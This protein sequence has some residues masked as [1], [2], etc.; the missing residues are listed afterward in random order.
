[1]GSTGPGAWSSCAAGGGQSRG[2][3]AGKAW[4]GVGQG[5]RGGLEGAGL[6]GRG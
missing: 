4:T 1:M 2:P 6:K 3:G 5:G